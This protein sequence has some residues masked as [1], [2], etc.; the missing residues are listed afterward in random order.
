MKIKTQISLGI[1]L[2][3]SLTILL[4]IVGIHKING[5]SNDTENILK[6][7]YN[8]LDYCRSMLHILN[9]AQETKEY[10][11]SVFSEYLH[12]QRQNIT[13]T[14]EAELNNRLTYFF[15]RWKSDYQDKKA[16]QQMRSTIHQLM[17][18]NMSAIERKSELAQNNAK[19]AI[20]WIVSIGLICII[21][22]LALFIDL[23]KRITKPILSLSESIKQIAGQNYSQRVYLKTNDEFGDL[24][25][26]FNSMAEK[27]EEY[28]KSS[29]NQLILE[30][31]RVESLISTIQDPVFGLDENQTVIFTNKT[32]LE[33]IGLKEEEC[34][35]KTT[36]EL[37]Q[38]NDLGRLLFEELATMKEEN[39]EIPETQKDTTPLKI[40]ANNKEG[41]FEKITIAIEN[42]EQQINVTEKELSFEEEFEINFGK[43]KANQEI[44][45]QPNQE[46]PLTTQQ[47]IAQIEQR[48]A[49]Q[50]PN[51]VYN[52][53]S[54]NGE[55]II[56]ESN[57]QNKIKSKKGFL[58]V[59]K[60]ITAYKELDTAKTN[61]IATV[62]HEFKTPIAAIRMSLQLLNNNSIGK[63]NEEQT[64]LVE[65][66][67]EDA[68]RLLKITDEL[69][70]MTQL[71]SGN[72]QLNIRP[73]PAKTIV[74]YALNTNK[75][76]AEQ[77]QVEFVINQE[78]EELQVLADTEKSAWILTN[79]IS[80]AI[81]YS[82]QNSSIIISILEGETEVIFAVKD[83]G[84]G[85]APEYQE[86]IFDRYFRVPNTNK[87][88]TGLGLAIS[89]EFVEA[90]DG[91]LG[92][93]S[94]L[95]EG[96]TFYFSL[97]KVG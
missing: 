54:E 81:R 12:Q 92:V 80:N 89:K 23:P 4:S 62:S 97:K 96:S 46:N 30:K 56:I 71:E 14:G 55:E 32:A 9:E 40:Y 20:I 58:V 7:N 18:L 1:G 59:L 50:N 93:E 35:G 67:D 11:F 94:E 15:A 61:F 66:I 28:S 64:S 17:K 75:T 90:Q 63:L 6:A 52:Q 84:Q 22:G 10:T 74:E 44:K 27:L 60:D 83:N 5:L 38:K 36:K 70:N 57:P 87:Q 88:G 16:L 69:L 86:K 41:F 51:S 26:T 79:L 39:T 42:D 47:V 78:N 8:T 73:T 65:S 33:I 85:I 45:E 37:S 91:K 34:I 13:E 53:L 25:T 43:N 76:A 2:L 31:K 19:N 29:L 72:I 24:A 82:Y 49:K 3:F 95:G 21:I 48:K 68:T 77:R